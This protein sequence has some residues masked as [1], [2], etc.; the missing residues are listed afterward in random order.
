MYIARWSK[1]DK[2]PL[3]LALFAAALLAPS[4]STAQSASGTLDRVRSSG[5]I[6]FGYYSA[7]RPLSYRNSA[8]NADG[9]SVALCRGVAAVV[10]RQL[11]LSNLSVQFV[12]IDSD[13]T[14]AVKTGRVDMMCG[15]MQPTLSR[16]Q[17][18]SF[19]IPVFVSG[20]SVLIRKD[21]PAD[22]R[23]LLE[24]RKT[25]YATLWRGSPQLPILAKRKFVVVTGT[26][27]QRWAAQRKQELNVTSE[28]TA[29]PDLQSGLQRV[30]SGE[31][32][33]FIADR[34]VL[35]DL[36]RNDPAAKDV[37]VIDHL[38]DVTWLALPLPRG[39]EDFRLLVDSTLS[40]LYRTGKI[41]GIYEKHLGKP[42]A[43]TR[44]WFRHFANRND[45]P[46]QIQL[47]IR[48]VQIQVGS[49]VKSTVSQ[50][51]GVF[52]PRR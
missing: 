25:N 43:A 45:R 22:F 19:S 6:T 49:A 40:R 14:A 11:N 37:K 28:I 23:D 50:N 29:V 41:D 21:A 39:D 7:A 30:L 32:D 15:P 5:K 36:A 46:P 33:A 31:S 18:V 4:L 44:D 13:P 10:K 3:G 20:T 8:G 1:L 24:G 2:A 26:A 48:A 17:S 35:I 47:R 12:P 9:Y 16:R 34:S 27:S 38:F 52:A 51:C 42:D